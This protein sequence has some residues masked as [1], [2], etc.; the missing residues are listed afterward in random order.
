M[1]SKIMYICDYVNPGA[2][3]ILSAGGWVARHM[4]RYC[5]ASSGIEGHWRLDHTIN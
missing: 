1:S 4:L 5:Q 3:L 2:G